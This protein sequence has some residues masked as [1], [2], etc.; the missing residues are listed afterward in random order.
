MASNALEMYGQ[1]AQSKLDPTQ[2]AG[3]YASQV[4][5]ERRILWDVSNKL[6]IQPSDHLLEIGSGPGQIAIPLSFI[7]DHCVVVDHKNVVE[8]L[9]ARFNSS[10][11][12]AICGDFLEIEIEQTFDKILVYSVLHCL[13][14]QE[15]V[16]EFIMKA[17]ALL[18]PGGVLLLGDI[19]NLDKK[20]RFLATDFGQRFD[21]KFH[22]SSRPQDAP[23]M[24]VGA[25]EGSSSQGAL[26]TFDDEAL[27]E[28]LRGLRS[29]GLEAYV[30]PQPADLPFGH[31]REDVIAF[32]HQ[33]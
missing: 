10:Q 28:I 29:L 13:P 23:P 2:L 26:A 14:D 9:H 3:R 12:T 30:H 33:E 5:A 20:A 22:G 32:R 25:K 8:R 6:Q 16:K 11:I 1:M 21:A 27:L 24:R 19:P 4:S 18:R 7:V 15:R 17:A 31:T